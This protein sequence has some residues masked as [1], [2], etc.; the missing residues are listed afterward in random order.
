MSRSGSV[1]PGESAQGAGGSSS[2]SYGSL[3]VFFAYARC[4]GAATAMVDEAKGLSASGRDVFLIEAKDCQT[5][6]GAAPVQPFDADRILKRRPDVAVLGSL[7]Q[8]NPAGS[9]NRMRYQDAE[10]LLRAGIDVYATLLVSDLQNEHDHVRSLGV[11]TAPELVPDYMLYEADQLEFVD[12]DPAELVVKQR[13]AGIEVAEEVLAALRV[14]ALRCVSEHAATAARDFAKEGRP[15][16]QPV[17]PRVVAVVEPGLSPARTLLE[18]SLIADAAGADLEVVCVLDERPTFGKNLAEH[19]YALLKERVEAM[20]HE[21]TTFYGHD[22]VSIVVDYLRTQGAADV[23]VERRVASG[24]RRLLSPFFPPFSERLIENLP[25][26]NVHV[27]AGDARGFSSRASLWSRVAPSGVNW[28]GLLFAVVAVLL[29]SLLL[30]GLYRLGA[31]EAV[32]YPL[33][34]AAAVAAALVTRGYLPA[35]VASL[36]A[37]ASLDY[38]GLRP[39]GSLTVDHRASLY[40]LVLFSVL[41]LALALAGVRVGRTA[42]RAT[43]R[44][45]RT[46]GLFD[47]NRSLLYAHSAAEVADVALGVCLGLFGRSVGI[48]LRDPFSE[49]ASSERDRRMLMVRDAPGDFYG[50]EFEKLTEQAVAHWVF[51]NEEEAGAGTDTHEASDI[52]YLPLMSPEGIEGVLALSCKRPLRL[53]DRSFLDLVANEVALALERQSLAAKHRSDIQVMQVTRIRSRFVSSMVASATM[54]LDTLHAIGDAIMATDADERDRRLFLE[55]LVSD[56]SARGRLMMGRIRRGMEQ[57]PSALCN[58]REEVSAAVDDV[59]SGLVDKVI[60][61]EPGEPDSPIVADATL[62]RMAVKLVLEASTSYVAKRGI[63]QVAV[64]S[65]A[66]RVDVVISDDRPADS[67]PSRSAAFET[68]SKAGEDGL[69]VFDEARARAIREAIADR[70]ALGNDPQAGMAALCR[71]MRLPEC[72]ARSDGDFDGVL[73]RQRVLRFDRLEYGLYVAALIVHAHGGTVKQRYRLGGGS[74]VTLA[75]P[76]S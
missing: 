63:V 53:P 4:S 13:A 6:D 15:K 47:L 29:T 60:D 21:L 57:P 17:G 75:F 9:R 23:V 31:A 3:K 44:E 58:V 37:A 55:R 72:A 32:A 71:A 30:R 42:L 64:R 61:F 65:Y 70:A 35:V 24:L 54:A 26:I 43:Q 1:G 48:Y 51:A 22:A 10:E 52:L 69:P 59:R 11:E 40:A 62:V 14:I 46:Q 16:D 28:R 66:D 34:M 33:L 45:R 36:L 5:A 41:T 27:V 67:S 50:E 20:G 39:F 2:A 76:R 74:V 12:I 49:S 56:E 7:A 38:L 19:E 18:A 25:S 68:A 8:V 73:N